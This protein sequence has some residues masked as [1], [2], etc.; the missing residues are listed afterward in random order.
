M[1]IVGTYDRPVTALTALLAEYGSLKAEIARRS[2]AQDRLVA[3]NLTATGIVAGFVLSDGADERLLFLLPLFSIALGFLWL[4]HARVIGNK[5]AAIES[6]A[7]IVDRVT[8]ETGLLRDEARVRV[9][10]QR[11]WARWIPFG[12]PIL[13]VFVA[14]PV[15]A[16]VRLY[17][18]PSSSAQALWWLELA[19]MSLYTAFLGAFLLAPRVERF[20]SIFRPKV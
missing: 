16:L 18:E 9:D 4:D 5:G 15:I 7:P 17:D 14:V 10:E 11:S 12:V 20:G 1:A 19:F 3:A 8:N 13:I 2:E 6:L